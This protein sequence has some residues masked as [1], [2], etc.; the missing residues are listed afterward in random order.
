MNERIT[1]N[2]LIE[3]L[4]NLPEEQKHLTIN[5]IGSYS[6]NGNSFYRLHIGNIVNPLYIDIPTDK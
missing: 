5:A 4:N 1:I 6:D 2:D 3:K